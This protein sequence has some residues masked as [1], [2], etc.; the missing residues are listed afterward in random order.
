MIELHEIEPRQ[1]LLVDDGTSKEQLA[2]AICRIA[3]KYRCRGPVG[4]MAVFGTPWEDEDGEDG[5]ETGGSL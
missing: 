5:E 1:F 3:E 2:E 4:I